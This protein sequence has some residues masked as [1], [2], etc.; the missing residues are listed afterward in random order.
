MCKRQKTTC[1]FCGAPIRFVRKG[2]AVIPVDKKPVY[3][4]PM[5]N[6]S[7][8]YY[9]GNGVEVKGIYDSELGTLCYKP[10]RCVR[11]PAIV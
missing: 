11:K 7:D 2:E 6:C 8:T 5:Y 10:H 9:K 3:I 4:R 1:K